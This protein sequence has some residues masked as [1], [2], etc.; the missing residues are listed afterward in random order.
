MEGLETEAEYVSAWCNDGYR[1]NLPLDDVT[2]GRAWIACEF[3]GDPL[4]PGTAARPDCWSRTCTSGRAPSACADWSCWTRTAQ[5]FW[6]AAGYHNY[7]DSWKE[8]RYEGD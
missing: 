1:T 8:Q 3:D 6:E 7:G 5:G 4:E 2:G